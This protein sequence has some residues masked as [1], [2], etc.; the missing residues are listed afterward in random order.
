VLRSP[1][2]LHV[3]SEHLPAD[4]CTLD[5]M[6]DTAALGYSP[7]TSPVPVVDEMLDRLAAHDVAGA[8]ELF[9]DDVEFTAPFVPAPLPPATVGRAAVTAMMTMVFDAYGTVEFRNRR[10]LTTRDGNGD[11]VV[12]RWR[13]NIEVL[14][15]GGTYADEVVAVV[16]IRDGH[17]ARFDEYFNPD[18]LRAAGVVPPIQ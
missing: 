13:T 16:T 8:A 9:T 3:V 14:A 7:P 5:T 2:D 11:V 4:G 10:Y 1:A 15:S 12:G 18:S 6:T 17:V